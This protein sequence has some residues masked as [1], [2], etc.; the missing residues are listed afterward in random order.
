MDTIR[1]VAIV[2]LAT[3]CQ[4]CQRDNLVSVVRLEY[5]A[6]PFTIIKFK[7]KIIYNCRKI[8]INNNIDRDTC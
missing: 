2:T 5:F 3:D 6:G 7:M 4:S 8:I 1:Y